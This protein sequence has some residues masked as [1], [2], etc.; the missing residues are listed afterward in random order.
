MEAEVERARHVLGGEAQPRRDAAWPDEAG[1]GHGDLEAPHGRSRV[2]GEGGIDE[3][4]RTS[5]L[6]L[7]PPR[8]RRC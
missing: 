4:E 6:A 7:A 1:V 5:L 2:A 3:E 8:R